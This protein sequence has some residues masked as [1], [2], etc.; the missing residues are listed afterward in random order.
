MSTVLLKRTMR[1]MP[2]EIMDGAW[3][4][5]HTCRI[6]LQSG[7]CQSDGSGT[8]DEGEKAWEVVDWR[9]KVVAFKDQENLASS[10]YGD[11]L[12]A[13]QDNGMD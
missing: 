1:A 8:T 13:S 3:D 10:K 9:E 12:S 6:Y 7:T 11:S 2:G 5:G 4:D